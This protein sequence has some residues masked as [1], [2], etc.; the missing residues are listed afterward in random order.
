MPRRRRWGSDRSNDRHGRRSGAG[1]RK[2]ASEVAAS[3]AAAKTTVSDISSLPP[4]LTFAV[5]SAFIAR[6]GPPQKLVPQGSSPL[7]FAPDRHR[8]DPLAL[9]VDVA[10]RRFRRR[11]DV[12]NWRLE[13]RS[14][15]TW[16]QPVKPWTQRPSSHRPVHRHRP[17]TFRRSHLRHS[18]I[19]GL[20]RGALHPRPFEPSALHSPALSSCASYVRYP[21]LCWAPS[22]DRHNGQALEGSS[23]P[24]RW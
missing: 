23:T 5:G 9:D 6:P 13:I 22:P 21:S 11:L 14:S 8:Q 19:G 2:T 10:I 4:A 16:H 3:Q 18:T 20:H 7:T 24:H 1:H 12:S 17:F 15:N